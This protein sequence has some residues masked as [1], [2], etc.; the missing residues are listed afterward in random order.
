VSRVKPTRRQVGLGLN[1]RAENVRGAFRVPPERDIDVRDR[2]VLVVDDV[3]TTGST[4]AA[5]ARALKNSGAASV[6]VLTF[7]RVLPGDF[8]PDEA[9]PI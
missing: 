8:S 7:A 4:V 3:Y 6:D 9:Q 5:M 2:R 1:E